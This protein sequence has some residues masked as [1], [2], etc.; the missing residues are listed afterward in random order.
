[1]RRALYEWSWMLFAGTAIACAGYWTALMLSARANCSFS[2]EGQSFLTIENGHAIWTNEAYYQ[3][4]FWNADQV[5]ALRF[6]PQE[7]RSVEDHSVVLPGA[8]LPT[9]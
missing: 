1:M 7:D 2:F 6:P 5:A 4:C 3:D 8:A 9:R